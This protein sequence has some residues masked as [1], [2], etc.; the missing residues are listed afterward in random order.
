[1]GHVGNNKWMPVSDGFKI[2]AQAQKWAKESRQGGHC[3][4]W[5]NN[6]KIILNLVI[7]N[8]VQII[9]TTVT[10]LLLTSCAPP[11]KEAYPPKWIVDIN[12][13]T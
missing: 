7:L 2:K 11:T 13:F 12:L 5:R 6:M 3:G 1:M 8:L 9:L 4:S 10:I